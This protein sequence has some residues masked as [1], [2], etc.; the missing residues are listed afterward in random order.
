[1]ILAIFRGVPSGIHGGEHDH[2]STRTIASYPK[3]DVN[4]NPDE[5][6]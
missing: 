2:D 3:A 6:D 5:F 4:E 1:M